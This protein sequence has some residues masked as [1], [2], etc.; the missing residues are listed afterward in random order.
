MLCDSMIPSKDSL[1]IWLICLIHSIFILRPRA[2][3]EDRGRHGRRGGRAL[4]GVHGEAHG[5]RRG[6]MPVVRGGHGGRQAAGLR[7]RP[8]VRCAEGGMVDGR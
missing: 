2:P 3:Y 1:A 7:R 5:L 8:R 6:S 4:R